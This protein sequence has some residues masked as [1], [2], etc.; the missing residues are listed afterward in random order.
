H[1]WP[2]KL[3]PVPSVEVQSSGE[4]N[5]HTYWLLDAF[6]DGKQIES[7]NRSLAYA[8]GADTSGWDANQFLRPPLSTNRKYRKPIT[9]KVVVDREELAPYSVGDFEHIPTPKD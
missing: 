3:A 1:T 8:L 4:S 5:R 7:L 6:L 9:V 2:E